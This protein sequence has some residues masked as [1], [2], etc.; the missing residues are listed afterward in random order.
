MRIAINTRLLIPD[1]LEGVGRFTDEV[2]KRLVKMFP[3]DEFL[4]LFDR[5]FSRQ[6]IYGDNVEPRVV[7]PPA[8]HPV[9][10]Y[11]WF[12]WGVTKALKQWNAD[13]FFSSDGFLS[14]RTKVPTVLTV[15]DIAHVHFP[16]Q[17]GWIQRQ[18]Y[19]YFIP[20]FV[21]KS[22]RL[23]TVSRFCRED[24]AQHFNLDKSQILVACNSANDQFKPLSEEE[25]E[26]A[27]RRFSDNK[28]YFLYVGSINPR[29]NIAR[30]I[31]AFD[32]F[33]TT[34]SG[35]ISLLIAGRKGW[36]VE[37]VQEAYDQ[38]VHKDAIRFLGYV[39][40]EDLPLLV[41]GA[42]ALTYVSV[43]EGFGIPLLEAMHSD[44]PVLTSSSSALSEVAGEA[45]F[46]VDPYSVEEISAGMKHLWESKV[47]RWQLIEQGRLKRREYSWDKAAKVVGEAIRSLKEF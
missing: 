1:R 32:H 5:P 14:L 12:D 8:R 23:I 47:L 7:Y 46:K 40:D 24:I 36:L 9:L 27:R 44:V 38:A 3:D 42:F 10:F 28:P 43:F 13:V 39:P 16:E 25:I 31:R 26:Q 21:R 11:L 45:G 37:D 17:V 29:K 20:R 2:V 41:G 33:K 19:K 30:L 15:H 4:F 18:Y 6:F 22:K 34:A 35:D